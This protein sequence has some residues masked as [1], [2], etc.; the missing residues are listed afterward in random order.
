MA[1]VPTVLSGPGFRN[2]YS[3]RLDFSTC[4]IRMSKTAPESFQVL[5]D[6]RRINNLPGISSTQTF[7]PRLQHHFHNSPLLRYHP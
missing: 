2:S 7:D 6:K 3:A 4:V 5:L 1:L